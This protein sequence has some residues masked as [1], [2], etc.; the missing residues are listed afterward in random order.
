MVFETIWK[1]VI[2]KGYEV[3]LHGYK[4]LFLVIFEDLG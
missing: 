1:E 3:K 4:V 2:I